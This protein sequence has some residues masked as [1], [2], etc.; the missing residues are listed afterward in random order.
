MKRETH[1]LF[2]KSYIPYGIH[3]HSKFILHKNLMWPLTKIVLLYL[4]SCKT[5]LF[6][7]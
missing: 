2:D 5:E 4:F 6:P 3:I 1:S 7:V